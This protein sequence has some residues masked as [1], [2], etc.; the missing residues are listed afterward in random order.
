MLWRW[1]MPELGEDVRDKCS[2]IVHPWLVHPY[3]SPAIPSVEGAL[4]A[5]ASLFDARPEIVQ[6]SVLAGRQTVH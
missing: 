6:V 3:P 4:L 2:G 1:A 5:E